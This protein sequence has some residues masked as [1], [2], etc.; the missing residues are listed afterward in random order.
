[1]SPTQAASR[2]VSS[3]KSLESSGYRVKCKN[4]SDKRS[5]RKRRRCNLKITARV[6]LKA[7]VRSPELRNYTT[8]TR[9]AHKSRMPS[10]GNKRAQVPSK[11]EGEWKKDKCSNDIIVGDKDIE[12]QSSQG[13]SLEQS[14]C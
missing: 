5:R 2:L 6:K 3:S 14:V 13:Q 9:N 11:D 1:M 7:G 8:E 12:A 4:D 10:E